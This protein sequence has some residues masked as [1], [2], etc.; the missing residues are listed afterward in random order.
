V[1]P[2]GTNPAQ[3]RREVSRSHQTLG[4]TLP[5]TA[6][7][8]EF[9]DELSRHRQPAPQPLPIEYRPLATAIVGERQPVRVSTSHASRRA[10]ARVG[11]QA[12]TTGDTIHLDRPRP[13]PEVIAHELTHVAHPSPTPRFFD[14]DV[15]SPEERQ[16]EQVAAVMRRAPI[17]PTTSAAAMRTP[18]TATTRAAPGTI[19][20]SALAASITS[21]TSSGH[22][23]RKE[24][25]VPAPPVPAPPVPA[26][27]APTAPDTIRRADDAPTTATT[28]ATTTAPTTNPAETRAQFELILELLEERIL[29]QLER[30][31]GRYRGGF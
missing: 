22:V 21:P 6:A 23:Q 26:A 28:T 4:W 24:T 14:D 9:L 10:L 25:A 11:K 15:R 30:R 8:A 31:G 7:A 27:P 20:A 18:P 12:A 2:P 16:A 13:A 1:P 3:I 29:A 19:S 5:R 17:L